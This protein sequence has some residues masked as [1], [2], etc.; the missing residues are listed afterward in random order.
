[1]SNGSSKELTTLI[2]PD[3]LVIIGRDNT[4]N[5]TNITKT[6]NIKLILL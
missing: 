1:M 3:N 6:I 5:K 2:S 4:L